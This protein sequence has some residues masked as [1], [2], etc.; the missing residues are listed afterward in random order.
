M[1]TVQTAKQQ[2]RMVW[3]KPYV[4][5]TI[6][7]AAVD[8]NDNIHIVAPQQHPQSSG[9]DHYYATVPGSDKGTNHSCGALHAARWRA[10]ANGPMYVAGARDSDR[11]GAQSSPQQLT[12]VFVSSA[13]RY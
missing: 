10:K 8:A 12:P 4:E 6:L 3:G 7:P 9:V 11:D 13:Q 2:A 1:E 5:V